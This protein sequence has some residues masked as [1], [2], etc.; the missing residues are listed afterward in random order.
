MSDLQR[1]A[2]P[3]GYSEPLNDLVGRGADDVKACAFINGDTETANTAGSCAI[4]CDALLLADKNK[5]QPG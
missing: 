5:L 4:T 2:H 3:D 1:S